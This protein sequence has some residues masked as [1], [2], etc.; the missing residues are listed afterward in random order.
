MLHT[1]K[2]FLGRKIEIFF[3]LADGSVTE[4]ET[5]RPTSTFAMRK[6]MHRMATLAS[7][8]LE[9]HRDMMMM[10]MMMIY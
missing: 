9:D 7:R 10:V 2:N 6:H 8:W 5:V 1:F 4:Q 3:F